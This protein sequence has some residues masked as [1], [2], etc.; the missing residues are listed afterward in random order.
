MN[1]IRNK[2]DDMSLQTARIKDLAVLLTD[3]F[4]HEIIGKEHSKGDTLVT[5]LLEKIQKLD[6]EY[7]KLYKLTCEANNK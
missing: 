3:Y 5:I 6:D 1:E 2:I 7:I 4:Y